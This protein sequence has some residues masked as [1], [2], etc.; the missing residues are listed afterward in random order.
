MVIGGLSGEEGQV[1]VDLKV[2]ACV[3]ADTSLKMRAL[4]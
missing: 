3:T 2:S 4:H 1:S